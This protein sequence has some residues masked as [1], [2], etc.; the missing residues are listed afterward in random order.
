MIKGK[1]EDFDNPPLIVIVEELVEEQEKVNKVTNF[2]ESVIGR[3][4]DFKD[5]VQ[6]TFAKVLRLSK[7]EN[8]IDYHRNFTLE[9]LK[10]SDSRATINSAGF[11]HDLHTV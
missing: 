10:E 8:D 5:Y 6:Y 2:V 9:Q 4:D 7:I 1:K 11:A 3:P